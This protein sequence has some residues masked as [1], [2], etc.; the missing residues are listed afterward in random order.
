MSKSLVAI[1][2][3]ALLLAAGADG[4]LI[5]TRVQMSKDGVRPPQ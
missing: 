4:R 1:I 3:G 2:L 5:A